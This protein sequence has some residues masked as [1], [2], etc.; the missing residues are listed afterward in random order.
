MKKF[1]LRSKL[2]FPWHNL[3]PK[4]ISSFHLGYRK[5]V[6]RLK[7]YLTSVTGAGAGSHRG[8]PRT[9]LLLMLWPK[10]YLN[11]KDL[12]GKG[13]EKSLVALVFGIKPGC[14]SSFPKHGIILDSHK[15]SIFFILLFPHS[16]HNW[17]LYLI[18]WYA[19]MSSV[20]TLIGAFPCSR[21]MNL[22]WT[23]KRQKKVVF[24]CLLNKIMI[25]FPSF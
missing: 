21:C 1:F 5:P 4:Y 19:F 2:D 24:F 12:C 13:C 16:P 17:D 18:Y 14:Y 3:R 9:A 6:F 20:T 7:L 22:N 11:R 23:F 25:S 15:K 10:E 8:V